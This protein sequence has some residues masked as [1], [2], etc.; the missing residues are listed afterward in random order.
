[1]NPRHHPDPL[2]LT[3]LASGVLDPAFALVVRAHVDRCARCLG[4][5][6][7]LEAAGGALLDELAPT[8]LAEEALAHALARI[9]TPEPPRRP[10][11]LPARRKDIAFGIWYR[12]L[13]RERGTGV[14]AYELHVPAGRKMPLHSHGGLE[15]TCILEGAYTDEMG[16]FAAGD[17]IEAGGELDHSPKADTGADCVCL[18]ATTAPLRMKSLVAQAMQ[19]YLQ[20]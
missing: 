2:Y 1:M 18:I 19:L 7:A 4:E 9:E 5:I 20:L 6:A 3:R 11:V 8:P 15:L 12:P 17:F 13:Y 14:R 10:H 16:H